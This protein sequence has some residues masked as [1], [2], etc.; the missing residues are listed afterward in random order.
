MFAGKLSCL[1]ALL[2]SISGFS[3]DRVVVVSNSTA[4][5]DLA[6]NLCRYMLTSG[7][8]CCICIRW[9]NMHSAHCED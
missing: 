3:D 8:V 1:E 9:S 2:R 4:A 5:L 7:V 6:G